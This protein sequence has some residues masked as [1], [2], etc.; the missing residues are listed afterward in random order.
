[1]GTYFRSDRNDHISQIRHQNVA[2][3]PKIAYE[4]QNFPK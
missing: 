4:G 3:I 1:M 2:K